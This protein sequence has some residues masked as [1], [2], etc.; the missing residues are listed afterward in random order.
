MKSPLNFKTIIWPVSAFTGLLLLQGCAVYNPNYASTVPV[1][2]I[3]KESNAGVSSKDIIRELRRTHSVYTL[4]ANEL[5]R[6]RQ[7]GVQ[8]SVINFM[9]QTHLNAIRQEQRMEDYYYGYPGYGW[10]PYAGWGWGFGWGFG[11][12][13]GYWGLGPTVIIRGG[14][15]H[16]FHGGVRGGGRR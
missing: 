8:D 1:S 7:E 15:D 10:G 14:Y 6:L 5:A 2:D 3:V 12:P 16:D 9:E 11:Y 4:N 13:Y